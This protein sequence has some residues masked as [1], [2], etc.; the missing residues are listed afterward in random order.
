MT[1]GPME[2]KAEEYLDA[3]SFLIKLGVIPFVDRTPS[4]LKFAKWLDENYQGSF[5][6]TT[7]GVAKRETRQ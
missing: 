3:W 4:V 6:L 7:G 1:K 2:Q 5:N